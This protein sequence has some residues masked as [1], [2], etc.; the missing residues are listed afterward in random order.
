MSAKIHNIAVSGFGTGTNDK[1][2][3]YRPSYPSSAL[4]TIHAAL[5]KSLDPAGLTILEPGSGTGIFSRLLL[6]APDPSYPSFPIKSLVAIEP[7]EGMRAAWDKGLAKIDPA[8][9][10]RGAAKT[11]EGSFDDFAQSRV[12]PGTVDGIIVAQ[13]WHWCPDHSSALREVAQYLQPNG[14]LVFIWNLEHKQPGWTTELREFYEPY[15]LGTPQ[16][17]RGLWRD[18]FK[19]PAYDELFEAPQESTSRW[20][21]PMTED[22]L[23]ERITSKSYLTEGHLNGEKREKF[24]AEVRRII[25]QGDKEWVDQ[26]NGLF[27][28]EYNTDV[29]VMKKK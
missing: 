1:Y 21:L 23:V 26:E 13:A 24:L 27:K 11:V 25:R 9:E 22:Q 6:H 2:D 12:E 14:V 29:V 16:Y 3:Q 5:P 18:T 10:L 28:Y 20:S 7:S 4:Q 19:V 15:D 17:Y 8:Q